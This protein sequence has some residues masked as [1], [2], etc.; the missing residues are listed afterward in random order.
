MSDIRA[1]VLV[2]KVQSRFET[3]MEVIGGIVALSERTGIPSSIVLA[4]TLATIAV[5]GGGPAACVRDVRH[6]TVVGH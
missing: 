6:G 5:Y 2:R 1:A 4:Q 3:A